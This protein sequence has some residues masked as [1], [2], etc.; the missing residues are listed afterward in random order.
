[1]EPIST[2]SLSPPSSYLPRPDR[3][4]LSPQSGGHLSSDPPGHFHSDLLGQNSSDP[5]GRLQPLVKTFEI[6][7]SDGTLNISMPATHDKAK[8]S[9][10]EVFGPL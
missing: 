5:L 10:L 1:M 2:T 6:A 7:V 9:A 8:I 3:P 4:L